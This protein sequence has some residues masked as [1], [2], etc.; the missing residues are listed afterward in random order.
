MGEHLMKRN[1]LLLYVCII[2]ATCFASVAPLAAA[3][4]PNN[5]PEN[6]QIL[7]QGSIQQMRIRTPRERRCRPI[8]NTLSGT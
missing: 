3:D 2:A 5:F 8:C 7:S 6:V 1:A 4:C